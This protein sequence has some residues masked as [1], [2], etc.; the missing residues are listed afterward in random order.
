MIGGNKKLFKLFISSIFFISCNNEQKKGSIVV[1]TTFLAKYD[2]PE[3]HAVFIDKKES[4]FY[5]QILSAVKINSSEY[6]NAIAAI[7][8]SS[9]IDINRFSIPLKT[10]WVSLHIYKEK[11]YVY[12]PSEPWVNLH[13]AFND[14]TVIMN[15]FNDGYLPSLIEKFKYREDGSIEIKTK[16]LYREYSQ[17]IISFL[18]KQKDIA[19]IEF[20]LAKIEGRYNLMCAKGK[21]KNYPIIVNHCPTQRCFEWQFDKPDFDSLLKRAE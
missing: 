19:I 17:I 16:G 15:F 4:Y 1:D 7:T 10:E 3:Y 9:K 21:I 20:P 18:S 8:E 12:S 13:L 5:N 14:S 2:G 6:S 11:F